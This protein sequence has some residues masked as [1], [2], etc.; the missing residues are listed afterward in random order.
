M[1]TAIGAK[2][3]VGVLRSDKWDTLCMS[4]VDTIVG[5]EFSANAVV[6]LSFRAPG[7]ERE[8]RCAAAAGFSSAGKLVCWQ[9]CGDVGRGAAH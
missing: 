1:L 7:A 3:L 9:L 2:E 4:V 6:E 8:A 5:E